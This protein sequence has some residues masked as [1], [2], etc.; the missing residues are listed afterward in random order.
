MALRATYPGVYIEE[1]PSGVRPITAVATSTAAFVGLTVRGLDNRPE[2]LLSWADFERSFGGLAYDSLVSYAVSHFFAN[3]GSEAW[4]VRVP[5]PDSVAA[6][7]TAADAV[8]SG[9]TA[10]VLTAL[11]RGAWANDLLVDVDYDVPAGDAKAFNLTITDVVADMVE[12]F[13]NVTLDDTRPNYVEA[14][15]NDPATGS[16]LLS[17]VATPASGRPAQTGTVGGVVNL[18]GLANDQSYKLRVTTDVPGPTNVDVTVIEAGETLPT[19][20][21][22]LCALLERRINLALGAAIPGAEVT[23]SPT[24]AGAIRLRA[25]YSPTL[26]NGA[27][28]ATLTLSSVA[29]SGLSM[30]SLAGAQTTVNVGRFRLGKGRTV[31]GQSAAALGEDGSTYPQT[32]DLIGDQLKFSGMYAL[33]RVDSF[34]LLSIPDATRPDP[35]NPHALNA[36][37]SPNDI[38]SAALAYCTTR[39]AMLLVDPPPAVSTLAA[40]VDW[41]SGGLTAKGPNAAAYFPRIRASDPLDG[42]KPR[43]FAPGGAM[44]GVLAR[45]DSERGV[46]KAPAGT[47][48]PVRAISGLEYKLTDDE[49][50]VLNPLGL[51]CLRTFPIYGTVPWGSRTL[52]GADATASQW[53]YIPVRRLAL[54]IEESLFRGTQWAVFEPNDEPLWAQLRL[55]V[56]A[57]MQGLFRQG[58]FAG[59][60]PTQA[61]LV[62]C[63]S[64]TTVQSDVDRGIVNILVGFAPLKPAEFV[65]IQLQQLAGQTS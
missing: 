62:K 39:R 13:S 55:N 43:L 14:V 58:A 52:D 44:A 45:T 56:T 36:G 53:K 63:D 54:L 41:I 32:A 1:L 26:L 4:A 9:N 16:R 23:C 12:T 50:G 11:S 61:Y 10:L 19:T 35:A 29:P 57:F 8:A 7:I 34:N 6:A 25:A 42:F 38:W 24:K 21:V 37:L 20:L 15:V 49:N 40:G 2:R 5:K 64:T 51:N 27:L 60:T 47:A 22:G 33:D 48:E 17:V 65:F 59:S 28:D 18:A 46:W 3:G 30:L 31:A